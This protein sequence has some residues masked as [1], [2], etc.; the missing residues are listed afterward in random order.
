LFEEAKPSTPRLAWDVVVA[1]TIGL[2]IR[3][4]LVDAQTGEILLSLEEI[5]GVRERNV[6]DAEGKTINPCTEGFDCPIYKVVDYGAIFYFS[7]QVMNENGLINGA[8]P[9]EDANRVWQHAG[10][11]YDFYFNNFNRDSYNGEGG[12]INL[13]VN[14]GE[15]NVSGWIPTIFHKAIFC[16]GVSSLDTVAHEFTHGI[17]TSRGI[18][19]FNVGEAAALNES[20]S[21]IFAAFIDNIDP[22]Q[23]SA[24]DPTPD[25]PAK[26]VYRDIANPASKN[27]EQYKDGDAYLNSTIH[28][29]AVYLLSE[30]TPKDKPIDGIE[31]IGIGRSKAQFIFYDVMTNRLI[32]RANFSEAR[33]A[34]VASCK[35]LVGKHGIAS[36]D[37]DQVM[38]A[39]AAVG[40]G[41]PAEQPSSPPI[42]LPELPVDWLDTWRES[43]RQYVDGLLGDWSPLKLLDEIQAE[44]DRIRNNYWVKLL[45]CIK[46]SDQACIDKYWADLLNAILE[47]FMREL[48][49]FCSSFFILPVAALIAVSK[50]K[51]RR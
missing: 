15:C 1:S 36:A 49:N 28:S 27:Y 35:K 26:I 46:N 18:R 41:E 24:D 50:R 25:L 11:V 38:N 47:L 22:W 4:Y 14:I 34:A 9:D 13:Y 44:I 12:A 32:Y 10:V 19:G 39:Y 29:Y 40:I 7:K 3:S 6:W 5:M 31:V 42:S 23:I 21:D 16:D 20:F 2:S 48:Y 37:C 43:L 8:N 45:E 51:L 33:K 17:W 30:G